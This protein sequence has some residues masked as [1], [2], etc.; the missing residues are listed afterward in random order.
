MK[1]DS[2]GLKGSG[3]SWSHDSMDWKGAA[4]L[5]AE[6]YRNLDGPVV[7][8]L[9]RFSI[10][11]IGYYMSEGIP[12]AS[13]MDFLRRAHPFVIKS[14]DESYQV[15]TGSREALLSVFRD[16]DLGS[17]RLCEQDVDIEQLRIVVKNWC[18][19]GIPEDVPCIAVSIK[20]KGFYS[21]YREAQYVTVLT[22][23]N[24]AVARITTL[25]WFEGPLEDCIT[26]EWYMETTPLMNLET[27]LERIE[28]IY[29]NTGW[30]NTSF[31][32]L[33]IPTCLGA[34][35]GGD[36]EEGAYS[37]WNHEWKYT[38]HTDLSSD[39]SSLLSRVQTLF[40]EERLECDI[41]E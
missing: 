32:I 37:L 18:N 4:E 23:W 39:L 35:L 31:S 22:I 9:F 5:V 11:S 2:F 27:A 21:D 14:T 1:Q 30:E 6:S 29:D 3:Y 41:S 17:G 25:D 10:W 19:I 33:T 8:P 36:R 34:C 13:M 24:D 16:L 7:I 38:D 15:P 28:N 40:F 26:P 12:Q 20:C